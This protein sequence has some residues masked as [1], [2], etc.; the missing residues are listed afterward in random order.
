[1]TIALIVTCTFLGLLATGSA[2]GKLTKNPKIL[3]SLHGVGVKDS[4]VKILA[5]LELLGAAGLVVGI[6]IPGL[7]IAAAIGLTLYFLGAVISHL[8]Q[9]Q[10]IA[11]W[12]PALVLAALALASTLLQLQR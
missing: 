2:A 5:M 4:Q 6:F 12:A 11:E 8:R 1:M 3:E 7:G 10:G 9:H